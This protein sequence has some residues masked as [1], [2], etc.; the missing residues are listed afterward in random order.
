MKWKSM[1]TDQPK[2]GQKVLMQFKS[3]D[4]DKREYTTSN[5][6]WYIRN[7]QCWLDE[8]PLSDGQDWVSVEKELPEVGEYV[9]VNIGEDTV[10]KGR[11]MMNGWAVMYADGEKLADDLRPVTHHKPL[12]TPPN[13]ENS[14]Q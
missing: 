9:L 4:Y 7:V 2:D 5:K 13:I 1:L 8:E 10:L 3:F 14:N 6:D 12:P 11:L